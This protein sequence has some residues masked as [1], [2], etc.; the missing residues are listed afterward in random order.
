[1]KEPEISV[2]IAVYNIEDYI[3]K[4]IESVVFQNF[5]NL[6]IILCDDGSTDKSGQICDKYAEKFE[7]ITVIHK[8]NGGLS[9][10]R[11][12]GIKEARG[13]YV[14]FVD[15]DDLL[16]PN[17]LKALFENA[18]QEDADIVI[19]QAQLAKKSRS[20]ERFE[21]IARESFEKHRFYSGKEYLEGCLK[22]GA[23]RVEVWRNLYKR[24]FLSKNALFFKKGISHEDEEFTPRALL[25]AKRVVLTDEVIYYYNND[26]ENSITNEI[27]PK[28]AAD[29]AE[30][31][32][33]LLKIFKETRP[34]KLRRLLEDDIAWKYMDLSKMTLPQNFK[35]KRLLPLFCAYGLKRRIKA[36]LFAVSPKIYAKY[37]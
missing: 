15:G 11:N 31:Y 33:S 25:A 27:N 28:K 23:L 1:M 17:A 18:Q 5:D 30:I 4:C 8:K 7:N 24:E 37:F 3:E 16:L 32:G 14:M 35:I 36:A 13:K 20:M 19:G 9:D 21:R 12:R 22:G 2:I 29:K 10:A 26:R 34:R 6:Q